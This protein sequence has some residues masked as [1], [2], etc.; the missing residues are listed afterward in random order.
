MLAALVLLTASYGILV[1][2]RVIPARAFGIRDLGGVDRYHYVP[3]I[4]LVL[5]VCLGLHRLGMHLPRAP[6]VHA[7]LLALW[8]VVSATAFGSSRWRIR[9]HDAEREHVRDALA[10]LDEEFRVQ[11]GPVVEIENRDV[12]LTPL[13][14]RFRQT[15]RCPGLACVFAIFYP[16]NVVHGRRVRF[17]ER[18]LKTVA[19][20][21]RYPRSRELI[22]PIRREPS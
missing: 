6:R 15:E 17:L 1:V 14:V 10:I 22:V 13:L 9:H 4:A 2:G 3:T 20:A 5:I 19:A 11:T 8:L 21:R 12:G 18:N 16:S 7:A